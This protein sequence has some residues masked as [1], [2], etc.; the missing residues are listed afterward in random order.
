MGFFKTKEGKMFL[1]QNGLSAVV[2][3]VTA[4]IG[5]FKEIKAGY[6]YNVE[7]FLEIQRRLLDIIGYGGDLGEATTL[8]LLSD[9]NNQKL[10]VDSEREL[11]WWD[12]A[13]PPEVVSTMDGNTKIIEEILASKECDDYLR[14][15]QKKSIFRRFIE[16]F[17][18]D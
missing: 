1:L 13:I 10:V 17:Q 4:G 12:K 18:K 14:E 8:A 3:G 6:R 15:K 5:A 11:R 16:M 2:S 7:K 9:Y